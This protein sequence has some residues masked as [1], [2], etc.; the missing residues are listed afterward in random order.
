MKRNRMRRGERR[1]IRVFNKKLSVETKVIFSKALMIKIVLLHPP[2]FIQAIG[3]YVEIGFCTCHS[4]NQKSR[5]Y[6]YVYIYIYIY[7]DI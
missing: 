4:W 5:S 3:R 1:V 6:Q 7:A 2:N